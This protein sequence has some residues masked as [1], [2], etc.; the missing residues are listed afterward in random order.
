MDWKAW[1]IVLL[2]A[3]N[4]GWMVLDGARAL[5]LGDYVTAAS[6][7]HAGQLG[8]WA[9]LV[10]AIGIEPRSALMKGIFV[11]YGLAALGIT[12]CFVLGLPWARNALIVVSVLGLWYL[13]IGTAANILALILLSLARK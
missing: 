9:T 5:T 3:L 2:I 6:G 10:K 11:A 1:L 4:A 12:G 8:P 7:D 13:P